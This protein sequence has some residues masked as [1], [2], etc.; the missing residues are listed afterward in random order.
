[1]KTSATTAPAA[2]ILALALSACASQ[3]VSPVQRGSAPMVD[4]SDRPV[5]LFVNSPAFRT[6][7]QQ[8]IG[9]ERPDLVLDGAS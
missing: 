7:P 3:P 9:E 4:R 5:I 1:M 2:I 8:I 6:L